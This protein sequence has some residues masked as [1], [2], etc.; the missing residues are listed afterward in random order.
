MSEEVADAILATMQSP[1]VADSNGEQANVVDV[2]N[3]VAQG[4]FSLRRSI[5]AQASPG[6]DETGGHVECLTEAVMGITSGLFK[7]ADAIRE[8]ADAVRETKSNDL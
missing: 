3:G 1:N 6:T 5:T 7:I 8:L 4:L 2:I